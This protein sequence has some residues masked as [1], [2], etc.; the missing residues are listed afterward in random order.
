MLGAAGLLASIAALAGVANAAVIEHWWNI[1]YATANPDGLFQRRVIGVNGSWPPPPIVS[2]QGDT[3]IVHAYNGLGGNTGTALHT[4]GMFFNGT[5]HFDGAV[6]TTQCP[7]PPGQTL[8][9]VI[10]TSR[11]LGTFW[12]HGHHEG[13]Y[14]DGLR[15]PFIIQSQN[16]TGRA[17]NVT[18]DDEFTLVASDWYH[19]EY[20]YLIDSQF[21]NWKNPTGAEPVPKSAMLYLAHNDSYIH[22][23]DDLSKAVGTNND[24]ALTF[25]AGKKYRIRI[26]NMS[27][28]AMFFINFDQHDVQI[29]EV[30]GIEVEAYPIS[31]LTIAIGQRYSLLVT[32]KNETDRNY[33]LSVNQSP[34]MYDAIPDDLVLN[35]TLQIVYNAANAPAAQVELDE[36]PM[37]DDTVFVPLVQREMLGHD[38]DIRLDAFF[39][40]YDDGT[41]RASFNNITY[42]MPMT[43]TIFTALSMGNNSFLPAV[44]GAQ[45]NAYAYKHGSI[46]QMTVFNWDAGFHP[47]HMHGHEFQVVH[48]SYD[49]TSDDPMLNPP[50]NETQANPARRDTVTIPPTGSVTIRWRADNPGAWLFHCHVDWHM[51]SGLAMVLVEAPERMQELAA[52]NAVPQQMLDHCKYWGMA[53]TGNIVG[54]NSTTDFK[55]Q[56]W[57]PFPI[58]MGWTP[59]AIGAMAGCIIT[60]LIGVAS[61]VFYA[62]GEMDEAE[63]EEEL[64]Y[65]AE[66]KR[67]K[68][69]LWARVVKRE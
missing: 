60:F 64:R 31:T 26:I 6:S 27:A 57:G 15:A 33:A 39:D 1:S 8:D 45:T 53:T 11:Q 66:A 50:F 61:I 36:T 32:A 5:N 51:S 28:L 55:G 40:T 46:V 52:V 29:I 4:H 17:D 44:Y 69:S 41:N 19:D 18:W 63:L 62:S 68:K 58:V 10:D 37:L 56:P 42:Q 54:K 38:V 47:F 16:N 7:I 20:A 25:E 12:I 59:K 2:T 14:T 22:S 3:V 30:D 9:Y 34:D 48:K 35:N 49:V 67:N 21:L 13:Q 43:P 23:N 24:A 65:K